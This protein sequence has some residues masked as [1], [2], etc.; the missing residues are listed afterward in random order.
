M[1]P[2]RYDGIKS[3]VSVNGQNSS[4]FPCD[5]G[6]RQGENLSPLL[7][8]LYL[9]DLEAYLLHKDLDGIT[10]DITSDNLTI[11]LRLFSLL[12]A[13]DTILMANSPNDL[14]NCLNAFADYCDQWKLSINTEKTKILIFG[15]RKKPNLH[16]MINGKELDIVENYKYLGVLFSQPGSFLS[17][18][19]HIAQQAKKA[20]ILL[21]TRINNLDLPID[22]QLKLFDNTI[23]PIL[24]YACEIWGYENLDMIEKIHYDFLRKITLS[25]KS[26][27]LYMLLAELGRYPL[28]IT[29]KTRMIGFWNRLIKGQELKI[30]F[31]LYQC[32]LHASKNSKWLN[33]I[34]NILAEVGRPDIWKFQHNI[35]TLSLNAIVKKSLMDQYLQIW[36]NKDTQSSKAL[37]YFSLKKEYNIENYLISL[38]KKYYLSLFRFRTGN[39]RLPVEVGRWEG[40]EVNERLCPKCHNE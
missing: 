30:S 12:Y 40:I 19:K 20:M 17:A 8:A 32:I 5:V 10:I 37:T 36:R 23:L 22:L 16:F 15:I 6:V 25:K 28:E 21:F 29:I 13:D 18:R 31:N 35:S 39:H 34:Q 2:D 3:S 14:Q 4:F 26:T 27:P 11:Y 33:H 24:T 38:P 1:L 9:N 7:F